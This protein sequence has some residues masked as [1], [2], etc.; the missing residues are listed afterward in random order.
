MGLVENFVSRVAE[1]LV[2]FTGKERDAETGLDYFGARYMSAAPKAAHG[3]GNVDRM[4]T[5]AEKEAVKNSK[6]K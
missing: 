5:E 3:V 2:G 6:V 4:T 1:G